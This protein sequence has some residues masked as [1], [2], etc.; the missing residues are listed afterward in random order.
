M[1]VMLNIEE[2]IIHLERE[3]TEYRFHQ[4][5]SQKARIDLCAAKGFLSSLKNDLQGQMT[6]AF[7]VYRGQVETDLRN[8]VGFWE[9]ARVKREDEHLAEIYELRGEI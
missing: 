1:N 6:A 7:K 4:K 5:R 2:L 9:G 3:I 8:L